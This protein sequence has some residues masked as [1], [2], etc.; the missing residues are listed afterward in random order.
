MLFCENI[1]L[2]TNMKQNANLKCYRYNMMLSMYKTKVNIFKKHIKVLNSQN[3]GS[4]QYNLKSMRHFKR[5]TASGR[6]MT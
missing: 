3:S 5:Y 2:K 4:K 1:K 6:N